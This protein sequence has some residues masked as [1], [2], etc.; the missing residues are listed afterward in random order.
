MTAIEASVMCVSMLAVGLI[1]GMVAMWMMI[2]P[3]LGM[4]IKYV[5]KEPPCP[6]I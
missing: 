5:P 6:K 1:G 3:P 2:G 4:K